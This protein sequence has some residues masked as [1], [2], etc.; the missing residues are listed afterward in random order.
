[1]LTQIAIPCEG[2]MLVAAI[3][4]G[5][6]ETGIFFVTG[7]TQVRFGAHR[8]MRLLAD[9]FAEA[10]YPSIR[11][12]RRGVG[13]SSGEDPGF[14]AGLPD[15][16]AALA[17]FRAWHPD[18]RRVLG[19]G[20]CDGATLLCLEHRALGLEGLLLANPWVVEAKAGAPP[21]AA[22]R[23]RYAQQLT[24]AEGWKRVLTGGIDYRKA[25]GGVLRIAKPA[26]KDGLAARVAAALGETRTPAQI[27]L[28]R[29]DATAMAFEHEWKRGA[30][31]RCAR[32][33]RFQVE[34]L[35]TD[36]HSFARDGDFERAA[37][38]YVNVIKR[39]KSKA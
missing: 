9:A 26:V 3:L 19:F 5:P 13:D 21:P 32:E 27:V 31:A 7:G 24:S 36:A 20:L 37:A 4:G 34:M 14:E 15:A 39:F 22:I 10:G 16:Q 6:A 38:I 29:G 11:Y 25:I 35:D 1:M 23:R 18:M 17:A 12:D 33:R 28:A 2:E 30:L 8:G